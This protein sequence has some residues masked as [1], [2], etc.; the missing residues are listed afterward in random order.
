M[1][2]FLANRSSVSETV[3]EI[4]YAELNLQNASQDLQENGKNNYCK[5]KLIAGILGIICFVLMSA[6]MTIVLIT[7]Y[8]CGRCPKE[9]IT[10]SNNCYYISTERKPWNESLSACASKNSNLLYIDDEEELYML[11][12]VIHSSWIRVSQRS[13]NSWVLPKGL[14]FFSK[15]LS[16]TSEMDN[17]CTFLHVHTNKFSLASCLERKTHICK[18]QAL[19]LT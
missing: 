4:I 18:H 16:V 10:Y 3:Q 15:R 13:N 19:Q 12:F 11:N 1:H 6:V 8:Y 9:W 14:T 5:G 17:N 2:D 7:S